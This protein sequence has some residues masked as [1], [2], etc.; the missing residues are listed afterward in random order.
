MNAKRQLPALLLL[1]IVAIWGWTFVVVKDAVAVYGVI[2][3]LAVRFLLGAACLGA[4][5]A[6]RATAATLRAG[7]AIGLVMGVAFLLQTLGLAR[8][9]ASNTGLITGL[10]AVFAPLAN[11][12]LFGVRLP[13]PQALALGLSL[14]GLA[15]L[16]GAGREGLGSGDLLTLGCAALFGLHIALLD[17]F[18]RG[19]DAVALAFGQVGAA[20]LLFAAVWLLRGPFAWPPREVWMAL[21]VTGVLASAAAYL[22]QTYA[23]QHLPAV[24]VALILLAEPVFAVLFGA[25]LQGD[26]FTVLQ[27]AGAALM[28]AATALPMVRRRKEDGA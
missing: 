17:R 19:H 10:F 16:T 28:V 6:R 27:G 18:A 23:Q 22:V 9:S 4:V 14:A 2:P 12:L 13:W 25:W 11:R 20:A 26:R 5:S 15:L 1:V 7:G 24:Q 8:S 21:L 3:F